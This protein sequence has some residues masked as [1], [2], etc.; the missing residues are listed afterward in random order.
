MVSQKKLVAFWLLSALP[1]CK[2]DPS[3]PATESATGQAQPAV[4]AA[5]PTSAAGIKT[6]ASDVTAVTPSAV[7]PTAITPTAVTAT[8][9][10][11]D[12]V[13]EAGCTYDTRQLTGNDGDT[14]RVS[15]PAGCEKGSRTHGTGVYTADT[16]VCKAAI[17]AGAIT[18]EGGTFTIRLEPGRPAYRGSTQ[19]GIKSHDYGKYNKSYAVVVPGS[20]PAS[21][22]GAAVPSAASAGTATDSSVIEAG[23]SYDARQL[24]GNDGQTFQVACPACEQTGRTHG[25]GV[26][27]ADTAI[28]GAAVHAGAIKPEGGTVTI[29]LEPGRPAYRGSTQNGIKSHD[30]GQYSKSYAVVLP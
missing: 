8:G 1:A 9:R 13:I 10:A 25:T 19:N 29:R 17:H 4:T 12:E 18:P 16:H 7:T 23:C 5:A 20:A 14:Y 21:P 3:P 2:T 24:V 30:Y 15:C 6:P 27:T 11:H 28:C 26:Y 22:T